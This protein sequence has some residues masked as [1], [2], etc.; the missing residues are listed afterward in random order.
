MEL[1]TKDYKVGLLAE[2]AVFGR[3]YSVG[4]IV[5]ITKISSL[6]YYQGFDRGP[7]VYDDLNRYLFNKICQICLK[8]NC[9]TI[10]K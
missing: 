2:K 6:V 9:V 3:T 5:K 7:E 8:N 10:E 1:K 4:K